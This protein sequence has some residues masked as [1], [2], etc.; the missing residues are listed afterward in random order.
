MRS[1]SPAAALVVLLCAPR[2]LAEEPPAPVFEGHPYL[3]T[4]TKE[5]SLDAAAAR[6]GDG[7]LAPVFGSSMAA[8]YTPWLSIQGGAEGALG[9]NHGRQTY[10]T[11]AALRL[12]W[13]RPVLSRLFFFGGLGVT[14]FFY[15]GQAGSGDFKRGLGPAAVAGV[16]GQLTDRFRLRFEVRDQWL[17]F[18]QTDLPHNLFAS[19][20]L[21]TQ[22]R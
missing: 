4:Y 12:I 16:W 5:V 9:L 20:S 8:F 10:D 15:E 17:I 13:P 14:V 22:Y 1:S 2:A 11:R 19:L 18:G 21:V 7:K 3:S 6:L